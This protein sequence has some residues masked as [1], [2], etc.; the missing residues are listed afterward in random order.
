MVVGEELLLQR[1]DAIF[2]HAARHGSEGD[3]AADDG[4]S[5]F[6]RCRRFSLSQEYQ[7]ARTLRHA[8]R[9]TVQSSLKRALSNVPV[10]VPGTP[11]PR[12]TFSAEGVAADGFEVG[13]AIHARVQRMQYSASCKLDLR[14]CC[15]GVVDQHQVKFARLGGLARRGDDG[16][17]N[18]GCRMLT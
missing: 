11:I 13:A 9:A 10:P 18:G 6:M 16:A 1:C 2:L 7:S 12:S 14:A 8:A 17:F 5:K 3:F 15:C 4:C